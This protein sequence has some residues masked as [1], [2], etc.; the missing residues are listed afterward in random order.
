[1]QMVQGGQG[2]N[3]H[4]LNMVMQGGLGVATMSPRKPEPNMSQYVQ[5]GYGMSQS[6]QVTSQ[7]QGMKL[8]QA[9]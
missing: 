8:K 6:Q 7:Q 3:S 1:M 2:G 4:V 5:K 9:K